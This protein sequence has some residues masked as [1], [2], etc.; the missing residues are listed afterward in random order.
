MRSH[1]IH[2]FPD[3]TSS[4]GGGAA[5]S[6][7]GG[8]GSDL[9]PTN[10]SFK[11]AHQACQSLLPGGSS[12][13]AQSAKKIAAEVKWAAC[14]RS[15]GLPN[16]PDPDAKGAFDSSKFDET[17]PQFQSASTACQSL[18]N[19]VGAVPVHPGHR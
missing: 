19:E 14:M 8:P 16:F 17:A 18:I 12:A 5:I 13:P 7:H 15:H 4:P 10:P 9:G 3:P 11:A 2:D 6:T 1:G